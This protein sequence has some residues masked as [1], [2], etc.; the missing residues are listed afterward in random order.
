M[1]IT[2]TIYNYTLSISIQKAKDYSPY[3][4]KYANEIANCATGSMSATLIICLSYVSKGV[5]SLY[6]EH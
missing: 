6:S 4:R 1:T 2:I 3:T 5:R